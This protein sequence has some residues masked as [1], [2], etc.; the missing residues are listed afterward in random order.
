ML[1]TWLR[2][3]GYAIGFVE[4]DQKDDALETLSKLKREMHQVANAYY[5]AKCGTLR[6]PSVAD[7]HE[8]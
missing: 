4:H 7:E 8:T 5:N 3:I 1:G 2:Q 6:S